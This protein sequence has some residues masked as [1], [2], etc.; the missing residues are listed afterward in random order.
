M[1]V[2]IIV[3]IDSIYNGGLTDVVLYEID[4]DPFF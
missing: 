3:K 1:A 2:N 4:P